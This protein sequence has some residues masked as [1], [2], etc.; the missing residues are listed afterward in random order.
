VLSFVTIESPDELKTYF[1][2]KSGGKENIVASFAN[3]GRIPYGYIYTGKFFYD[4]KN[5]DA[6][7]AC[8]PL[9]FFDNELDKDIVM[10]DRGNC[11]FVKKIKNLASKGAKAGIVVNNRAGTIGDFMMMDDGTGSDIEIPSVLISQEDGEIIK[12]FIREN[13]NDIDLIQKIHVSI[14]FEMVAKRKARVDLF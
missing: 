1:K 9:A 13:A 3:F 4:I 10:V 5:K 12:N 11:T 6:E 7:Q 8:K 14:D 2:T